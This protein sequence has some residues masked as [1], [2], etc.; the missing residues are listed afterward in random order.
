MVI[1]QGFLHA[2][3]SILSHGNSF[4]QAVS[5]G[6]MATVHMHQYLQVIYSLFAHITDA[7]V[8]YVFCMCNKP[9][10]SRNVRLTVHELAISIQP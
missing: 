5:S 10:T 1:C 9:C 8:Q 3:L 7:D 6:R 4:A 2:W